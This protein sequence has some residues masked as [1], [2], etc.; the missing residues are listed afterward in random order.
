MNSKCRR[1]LVR[2]VRVGFSQTVRAAMS[3][4]KRNRQAEAGASRARWSLEHDPEKWK[5]IFRKD[6]AQTKR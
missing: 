1:A 2:S 4:I 5:P 6:H 3:A